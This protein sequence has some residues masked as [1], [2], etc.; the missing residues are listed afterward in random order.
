MIE[1]RN[2]TLQK[3]LLALETATPACSVALR[4]PDGKTIEK[5]STGIG[6]HSEDVFV[7][8]KA[9]LNEHAL[10]VSDLSAVL[11][12][13]GPGSYTGLR[14][15]SSAVKGL[16]FQTRIPLYAYNTLG[17]IAWAVRCKGFPE[18]S[19]CDAVIDARRNHVY[20][21][22]WE[23]CSDGIHP[24]TTVRLSELDE[25]SRKIREGVVVAGTGLD[26]L[27]M[28]K[29]SKMSTFPPEEV[30]SAQHILHA[31]EVFKEETLS[32]WVEE[33]RPDLFEP[34]YYTG[35]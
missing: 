24:L 11:V 18:I 3:P 10:G 22:S 33:V 19:G 29:R 28:E 1:N 16:L 17:A 2:K 14:V 15:A 13:S 21:Q 7:F 9:L 20:A 34:S 6:V 25:V 26:R 5:R 23:L 8:I 27:R 31:F 12:S 30:I 32:Q 35:L 4:L